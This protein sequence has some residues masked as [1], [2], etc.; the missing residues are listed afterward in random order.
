MS[1]A[2]QAK[3]L[4]FDFKPWEAINYIFTHAVGSWWT[5]PVYIAFIFL[6]AIVTRSMEAVATIVAVTN[7]VFIYY[8][9]LPVAYEYVSYFMVVISLA[10]V[11]YMFFGPG[12]E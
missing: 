2:E 4:F 8:D 12:R 11:L 6:I 10:V 1:I 3:Q 5:Y 7:I 9:I